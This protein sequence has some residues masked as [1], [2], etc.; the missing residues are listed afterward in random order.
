MMA[1]I[2]SAHTISKKMQKRLRKTRIR[3][4]TV[5]IFFPLRNPLL[6]LGDTIEVN[7]VTYEIVSIMIIDPEKG[8]WKIRGRSSEIIP[9]VGG[10]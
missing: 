2:K 4:R 8:G 3:I 9:I 5:E 1:R 7:G 10:K 6:K